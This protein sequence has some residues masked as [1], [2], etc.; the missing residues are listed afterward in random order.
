MIQ[1]ITEIM[2]TPVHYHLVI[3]IAFNVV[4]K[5]IKVPKLEAKR[6]MWYF[7]VSWQTHNGVSGHWPGNTVLTAS[8]FQG[9]VIYTPF[10]NTKTSNCSP[11]LSYPNMQCKI[12]VACN[13]KYNLYL[14]Q[15]FLGWSSCNAKHKCYTSCTRYCANSHDHDINLCM[16]CTI[17]YPQ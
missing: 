3:I 13:A 4:T 5:Y 8:H 17:F 6:M 10:S 15:S 16:T 2:S 12:E 7:P 1:Y 9:Q 14:C 11:Q